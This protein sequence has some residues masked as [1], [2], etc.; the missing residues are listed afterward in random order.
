[1][2]LR[3]HFK[4][5]TMGIMRPFECFFTP[6]SSAEDTVTAA[7]T[8][9]KQQA[10]TSASTASSMGYSTSS[11]VSTGTGD[12]TAAISGA[13]AIPA[14]ARAGASSML[15]YNNPRMLLG[16]VD[17]PRA[18]DRF[19]MKADARGEVSLPKCLKQV[20]WRTLM[21]QF[22]FSGKF[23]GLNFGLLYR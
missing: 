12:A 21:M 7:S 14:V 15:L 9:G 5:L 16:R 1:M 2:L 8:S 3:E 23:Y 22:A 10:Y 20:D 17:I 18:L 13:T 4:T 11:T 6:A 19:A